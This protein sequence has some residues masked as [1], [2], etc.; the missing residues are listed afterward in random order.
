M[1]FTLFFLAFAF[2]CVRAA[3]AGEAGDDLVGDYTRKVDAD[4]DVVFHF[5]VSRQAHAF[6]IDYS[7]I[8]HGGAGRELEGSGSGSVSKAG[9]LEFT[10]QDAHGNSGSGTLK[11]VGRS[12]LLSI[13]PSEVK[14]SGLMPFY[15]EMR[16]SKDASRKATPKIKASFK[17]FEQTRSVEKA[18]FRAVTP[19]KNDQNRF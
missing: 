1:R 8:L 17:V 4:S 15:G 19:S 7:G 6:H 10:F 13:D 12:F 2:N 14:E 18:K 16:L 3:H 9:V 5:Y 11:R